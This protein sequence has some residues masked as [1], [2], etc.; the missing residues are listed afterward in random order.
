MVHAVPAVM[1]EKQVGEGN[2]APK[3]RLVSEGRAHAA[4]VFDPAAA[5]AWCEYGTPEELPNI[6]HRKECEAG[7]EK[8]SDY[9]LTCLFVDKNYRRMGVASVALGGALN[10][11]AQAAAEWWRRNR[12]TPAARRSRHLSS[13]TA[14]V[15][16][17]SRPASATTGA[18]AGTT[19]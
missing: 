4:L 17:S 13:T 8:L 18:R 3:E 10:L 11:I 14:P 7:V 6:C 2:R 5:V 16:S 19:A 1:C 9:R 15:A 12:R